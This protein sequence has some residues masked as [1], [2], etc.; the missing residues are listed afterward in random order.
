MVPNYELP[1]DLEKVEILRVVIREHV[2]EVVRTL[3]FWVCIIFIHHL[4]LVDR[5]LNDIV[6]L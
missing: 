3:F 6:S 4:Q 5:L 1:P 2:T